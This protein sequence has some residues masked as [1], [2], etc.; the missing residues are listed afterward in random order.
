MDTVAHDA[1]VNQVRKRRHKGI[2]T[3]IL[4]IFIQ[5]TGSNVS[6]CYSVKR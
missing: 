5:D 2:N 4:S 1:Y 3:C 6:A